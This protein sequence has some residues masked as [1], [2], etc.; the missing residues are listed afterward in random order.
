LAARAAK[1]KKPAA[2]DVVGATINNR[3]KTENQLEEPRQ[4]LSGL[5][6]VCGCRMA[7]AA[8]TLTTT[9]NTTQQTLPRWRTMGDL[10][11]FGWA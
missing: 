7:P 2:V 6:N 1:E 10:V 3:R 9:M 5:T 11:A 4:D 8:Q